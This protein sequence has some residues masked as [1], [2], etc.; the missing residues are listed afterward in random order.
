MKVLLSWLRELCPTDLSAEELAERLTEQGVKVESISR[1]WERMAGV[2]IARVLEVRD[3]PNSDKL[4]LARVS[5]EAGERELV[6][7]VRNMKEGDLV[8]LAGS[9]ATVPALPEPLSAREIRGVVSEGMLCSPRDLGIS[10]DHSG[11][12][13]LPPDTPLGADFKQAFGLDDAV[14]DVEVK[15]NRPDLL[16]VAG[17]AREASAA[18]GVPFRLPDDALVEG[19]E[20]AADAATVDVLDLERCPRYLAKVIRDVTVGA[21][22]IQVQAR[23]TAMGMRPLSN[24]VDATNYV[25]LEMGQPMHPFDL[26]LL[27]GAAVVVRR[28]AD[29]ERLVT[30]DDVERVLTK[31][32]LLIADR[33]KGIATA[34]IFGSAAAEVS[35][36]TSDVLLESAHFQPQGVLRTAR[37]LGLRTEA[38]VRFERGTDPEAVDGAAD[39]AARLI[40]E[41]SGGKAL[42]GSIDVGG[43]PEGH[44]VAMR[45]SRASR[46]LGYDVSEEETVDAFARLGMEVAARGDSVEV[47]VPSYRWD[48][49]IEEDLVEEV[50]RILGY[51]RVP[52]TMPAVRQAGGLPES[53]S[54]RRRVREAMV[55]AG[56]RE[57]WNYS[58]AS[59]A[60]LE[61]MGDDSAQAIRVANPLTSDQEFLRTS[62]LP[63]LIRSVQHNASRRVSGAALFEVGRVFGQGEPV[64]ERERVGLILAGITSS[65]HPGDSHQMDVFDAK[66]A[67]E[68]LLGAFGV[69]DW[70]LEE[71]PPEPFH[72]GRAA[73][74]LIGGAPA[75]LVG[76]LHPRIVDDL[77]LP[78]RTSVAELDLAAVADHA[79]PT[80]AVREIPRFPPVHRDLAFVVDQDVP[81]GAVSE[82]LRQ[83]GGDLVD[84]V[85]LFDV[86]SG[87]P[88]PPGKKNV[89]FSVDF[90]ASDRTLTDEEVDRVVMEIVGRLT[91]DL[92]A[93]FRSG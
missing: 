49:H 75:G 78:A 11:I 38:S 71:A 2:V 34:G 57:A 80:F 56:L 10:P 72:P 92:G 33:S 88:L 24:V 4:C 82:A 20:K 5:F 35:T 89:A 47:G 79:P 36:S 1:P 74:V 76:E 19:D 55:R 41:W 7:G 42:A 93:E 61:L 53:Y 40:V 22:P 8:P 3:H 87:E 25:M 29:G 23:L 28:A 13:V 67:V 21:S 18:T 91:R 39:R 59:A 62:L 54:L 85:V 16:S 30:L 37:R 90:R 31:D 46:V 6:V 73:V 83:A 81:A 45:P 86:F 64:E 12:L 69:T 50:A 66:G 51:G 68:S 44:R 9:G 27:D 58:F 84:K 60:D 43:P 14:L 32:D 70:S 48:L 26:A 77:N 17:V 63:G 52:E 65:G 15:S